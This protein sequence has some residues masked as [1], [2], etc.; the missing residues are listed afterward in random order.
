M[1]TESEVYN[2]ELISEREKEKQNRAVGEEQTE[3]MKNEVND[4]RK[5]LNDLKN[6]SASNIRAVRQKYEREISEI[7]DVL[8]KAKKDKKLNQRGTKKLDRNVRDLSRKLQN[9]ELDLHTS[10]D[11]LTTLTKEYN[12][13]Q[14]ELQSQHR[15]QSSLEAQNKILQKD[16]DSFKLKKF[17]NLNQK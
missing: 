4:I 15:K 12:K 8:N 6:E 17:L 14:D 9:L 16:A 3:R 5:I 10:E 1:K 2:K 13:A 11:K 7:E